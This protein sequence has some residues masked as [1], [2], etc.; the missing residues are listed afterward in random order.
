MVSI[1]EGGG[2]VQH[3]SVHG[4]E[5]AAHGRRRVAVAKDSLNVEQV[6]V[7][8]AVGVRGAVEDPGGGPT[9]VVWGDMSQA[10]SF[11]PVVDHVEERS[12]ACSVVP[13]EPAESTLAGGA[14]DLAAEER[15]GRP[16]VRVGGDVAV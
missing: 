2:S 6:E 8:G 7:V 14:H 11:G 5:V 13:V 15:R 10:R 12:I 3:V 16:R 4:L 1:E 9:Q